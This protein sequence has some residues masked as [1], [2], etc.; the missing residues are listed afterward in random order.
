MEVGIT[1]STRRVPM[2]PGDNRGSPMRLLL[3]GK[4]GGGRSATGNTL[5]G[6]RNRYC[7]VNNWASGA[8]RDQQ[9][10]QL[11]E[12]IQQTHDEPGFPGGG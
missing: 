8:E 4:T 5:L 12:K 2:L 10:Q 9:V 1:T 7:C 11:M 3:V 6:R